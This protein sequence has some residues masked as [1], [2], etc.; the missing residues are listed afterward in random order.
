M[1]HLN[2][3]RNQRLR[4]LKWSNLHDIELSIRYVLNTTDAFYRELQNFGNLFDEMRYVR[5]HIAHKSS[6]TKREYYR[7]LRGLYNA[8]IKISLGAFLTSTK[9][10]QMPNINKY[11]ISI[12]VILDNITRG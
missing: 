3:S 7:I 10:Q 4:Y 2:R 5:N 11:I 6:S 8:P 12:Q 1:T 9:R